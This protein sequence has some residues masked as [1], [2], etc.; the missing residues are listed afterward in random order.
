MRSISNTA[1]AGSWTLASRASSDVTRGL[2]PREGARGNG[3]GC[4]LCHPLHFSIKILCSDVHVAAVWLLLPH[5]VDDFLHFS[6]VC[7]IAHDQV[8]AQEVVDHIPI[9]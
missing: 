5:L 1:D 9:N 8:V 4:G 3:L 2:S 6:V 7:L